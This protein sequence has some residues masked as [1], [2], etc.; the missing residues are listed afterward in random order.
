MAKI[1]QKVKVNHFWTKFG[2]FGNFFK[3]HFLDKYTFNEA[4]TKIKTLFKA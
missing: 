2:F 1:R 4:Q 3:V